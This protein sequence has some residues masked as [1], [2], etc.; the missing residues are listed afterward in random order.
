MH[1]EINRLTIVNYKKIRGLALYDDGNWF[2]L[3]PSHVKSRAL[4]HIAR[5]EETDDDYKL[6]ISL[7][8]PQPSLMEVTIKRNKIKE[9]FVVTFITDDLLTKWHR[10]KDINTFQ[11]N[12]LLNLLKDNIDTNPLIYNP[13]F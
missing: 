13:P 8:Q 5:I 10:T 9:N 3:V 1:K 12:N 7:I 4:A 11:M 2:D 6:Q